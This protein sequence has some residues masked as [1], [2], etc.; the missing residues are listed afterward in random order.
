MARGRPVGRGHHLRTAGRRI[1]IGV[2]AHKR[3]HEAV[4]L[5]P[6]GLLS[7]KPAPN[8]PA[9]WAGLLAWAG[10][11]PE[12]VWAIEGS[13]ALGRGLAQVLAERGERVHEVAPKWSAQRRRTRRKPGK[14]DRLDAHAVAR[15]VREEADALPLVLPEEP[16]A[17]SVELRS[18]LREDVVAGMTR[19]R[20]RLHALLLLCDPESHRHLPKLTTRAGLRACQEDTAPGAGPLARAREQAVRQLAAQ[21][22]LLARQE[23]EL[24]ANIERTVAD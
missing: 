3:R 21:L 17:A 15:L 6:D 19:L 5:G 23:R 14:S 1:W 7:H 2:A 12:P 8:T 4:A 24:R 16:A 13:G 10:A 9:G 20:N 22:A 11:W 18:R